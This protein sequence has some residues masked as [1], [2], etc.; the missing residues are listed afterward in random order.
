M[1]PAAKPQLHRVRW[2]FLLIA[3]LAF[4][5]AFIESADLSHF[6]LS[7]LVSTGGPPPQ[8]TIRLVGGV[9][10]PVVSALGGVASIIRFLM[11]VGTALRK[12][13]AQPVDADK[14]RTA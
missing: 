4:V 12:R 11:D 3:I 5:V 2:S 13:R 7:Y 10:V 1:Q 14:A 8:V 9:A 6:G